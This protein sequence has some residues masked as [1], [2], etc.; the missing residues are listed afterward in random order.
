MAAE[1]QFSDPECDAEDIRRVVWKEAVGKS[2]ACRFGMWHHPGV[3]S[4]HGYDLYR[5][6][7]GAS[8][9][10]GRTGEYSVCTESLGFHRGYAGADLIVSGCY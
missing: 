7:P 4:C 6:G 2:N 10:T 1:Y 9:F 8:A 3:L 5:T